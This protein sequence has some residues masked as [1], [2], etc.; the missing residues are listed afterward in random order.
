MDS[1]ALDMIDTSLQQDSLLIPDS[2]Q[3][4]EDDLTG[5]ISYKDSVVV[6]TDWTIETI[7]SQIT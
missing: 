5:V 4:A 2:Q 7:N 6:N 1:P 3:E